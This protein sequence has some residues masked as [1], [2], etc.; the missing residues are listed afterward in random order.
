MIIRETVSG[1]IAD[2]LDVERRAFGRPDEADLA[3]ELLHDPTAEPIL[4]LIG[5]AAGRAV[6]HILFTCVRIDGASRAVRASILAPLAVIPETQN[7]GYGGMLIEEGIRRLAAAGVE[8]VFVLGHP[9]YYPRFGFEPAAALGFEPPFPLAEK[10]APAWM[11]LALR[12]GVV[13]EVAGRVV[14]ADA[15]NKPEHW[16]E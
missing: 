10:D 14:S 7:Q 8:L 12:G 2:A 11:V 3:Q 4:S 1:D 9:G 16:K 15:L 6:G 13:G 5:H